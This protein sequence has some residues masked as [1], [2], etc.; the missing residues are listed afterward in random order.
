MAGVSRDRSLGDGVYFAP[1]DYLGFR[2]RLIIFLVDVSVVFLFWTLIWIVYL[3]VPYESVLIPDLACFF[4]SW[5]Y[6][7]VLRPSRVRSVG[8]WVTGARIVTLRG[9][10]PSVLRMTYRL[11][12]NLYY[13]FNLLFDLLWV[14]VDRDRQSLTDRYA[15]TCVVRKNAVPAGQAEIHYA[16]YTAMTYVYF[17]PCVVLPRANGEA[18]E[19]ELARST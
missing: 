11:M 18:A 15:G 1:D 10:K 12:L 4:C 3:S 5:C 6:L 19:V 13:P 8:Y 9:T 16:C 2:R 17:Y 7:A 14:G